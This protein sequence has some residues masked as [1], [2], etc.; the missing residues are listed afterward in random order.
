[1]SAKKD[2]NN[3]KQRKPAPPGTGRLAAPRTKRPTRASSRE[4]H[5]QAN[6]P[7]HPYGG[8]SIDDDPFDRW[9]LWC[10][11][12][13]L[14][15]GPPSSES[16]PPDAPLLVA[17]PPMLLG[18]H[19]T[20]AVVVITEMLESDR[21][22]VDR[23]LTA[24]DN[25][26]RGVA[27][28]CGLEVRAAPRAP[29]HLPRSIGLSGFMPDDAAAL[30]ERLALRGVRAEIVDR[31]VQVHR[32][33]VGMARFAG[34]SPPIDSILAGEGVT[35]DR[36]RSFAEAARLFWEAKPWTLWPGDVAETHAASEAMETS[37]RAVV[38]A[39]GKHLTDEGWRGVVQSAG[40]TR[41]AAVRRGKK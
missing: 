12:A 11:F 10:G 36:V 28:A 6:E 40:G 20:T 14:W 26:A 15:V 33:L 16:D 2:P 5:A 35:L 3:P 18:L 21:D 31:P 30:I 19:A 17:R 37:L 13:P 34:S 8:L 39:A 4:A 27:T 9:D 29:A 25:A 32:C 22:L 38:A 41:E 23:A 1:M 24:I 7:R